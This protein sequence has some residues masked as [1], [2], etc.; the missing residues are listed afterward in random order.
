MN[1]KRC[2]STRFL[3]SFT[4]KT[5]ITGFYLTLM[6]LFLYSPLIWEYLGSADNTLN[7]CAFTET[8]CPEALELFEQET[9]VKVKMTYVETDEQI[10]AKFKINQGQGYDVVNISDFMVQI[11]A[12]QDLLHKL[13]HKNIPNK[14]QLNTNLLH[15]PFDPLNTYSLPHKWFMYGLVYH[16]DFFKKDPADMDLGYIFNHPQDLTKSGLVGQPYRLC[17]IDSPRDAFFLAELYLFGTLDALTNQQVEKITQLLIAQKQW[18]ECYTLY[19]TEYFLFSQLVPIALTS[20]NFMRKILDVSNQFDFAIPKQGGILVVENLV[21]PKISKKKEMATRFINFM[22][23]DRAALINGLTYG[24][25]SANSRANQTVD[26]QYTVC[27]HLCPDT[28]IFK[29]LHIPLFS[30][31]MDKLAYDSW[32]NVEFA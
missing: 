28:T 11:L 10:Y 32:L 2:P 16:K 3:S 9:G 4:L 6:A 21:I 22:L 17:M 12:K 23:S 15:H 5:L 19:T 25:S 14:A 8:F 30:L 24:W 1:D 29:R 20:S 13:D 18:V 26:K 27:P 7:V 31:E